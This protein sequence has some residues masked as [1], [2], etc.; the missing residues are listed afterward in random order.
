M[1]FPWHSSYLPI[2]FIVEDIASFQQRV[3]L[4]LHWLHLSSDWFY[5]ILARSVQVYSPLP[6]M[7]Y[8]PI[9]SWHDSPRT[10]KLMDK[11]VFLRDWVLCSLSPRCSMYAIF[12]WF[13]GYIFKF[14]TWNIWVV[15]TVGMC[16]SQAQSW[17]ES[18]WLRVNGSDSTAIKVW[19]RPAMYSMSDT[20]IWQILSGWQLETDERRITS[21]KS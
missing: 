9:S 10:T 3:C 8:Q 16:V 21:S 18:S 14:R 11:L 15:L 6:V 5:T 7:F 20:K 12:V 1:V 4:T 17:P 13:C 19:A 2:L